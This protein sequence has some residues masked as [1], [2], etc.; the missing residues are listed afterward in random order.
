REEE[1][2][3]GIKKKEKEIE[4]I[5]EEL[6]ELKS[7]EVRY[8]TL[9]LRDTLKEGDVCP[10]CGN[11]Y[12]PEEVGKL[13][14]AEVPEDG[15]L[16]EKV[17]KLEEDIGKLEK[18]KSDLDKEVSKVVGQIEE[19]ESRI[20]GML[21]ELKKKGFNTV[22]DLDKKERNIKSLINRLEE[23]EKEESE[24]TRK[25]EELER[26][27][28][29]VDESYKE[30]VEP[31]KDDL[32]KLID[33]FLKNDVVKEI[34]SNVKFEGIMEFF[35]LDIGEKIKKHIESLE[36]SK[37]KLEQAI[38]SC[39]NLIS[40]YQLLEEKK[41]GLSGDI[42]DIKRKHQELNSELERVKSEIS[43][44][45]RS[46]GSI[47]SE[48]KNFV[49][50]KEKLEESKKKFLEKKW[51]YDILKSLSDKFDT[52]GIVNFVM[53][54]KMGEIANTVNRYL[55]DLGIYDKTLYV[56]LGERELAF[57]VLYSDGAVTTVNSLSGGES[58]L[59][60][61]ALAFAV[62]NDV[63][64]RL[65]VK[66]LFI[67]EG[68]DTLDEAFNSRLFAFLENFAKERGVTIYIITH[69][70]EIAKNTTYPRIKVS[71]EGGI[72]KAEIEISEV[73]V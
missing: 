13:P 37:G 64:T 34:L 25:K 38:D 32:K 56:E 57:S 19:K 23:L 47:S 15:E 61:V 27:Y 33:D 3:N 30:K 55:R 51:K 58:F 53:K 50:F 44:M 18:E 70:Q 4:S 41:R 59:F 21:D 6:K 66:S 11:T 40:K 16:L 73:T 2:T 20:G 26:L 29:D 62:A 8:F 48:F 71:K 46:L 49:R 36:G 22:E 28:K 72:S 9:R 69:K 12:H 14:F 39:Q 68:F 17:K 67:D 54:L 42:E 24:L 5:K 52:E 45:N 63:V 10:V 1:L 60:S 43:K 65:D 7:E 31:E 35:K